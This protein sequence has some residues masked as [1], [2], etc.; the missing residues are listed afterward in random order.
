M[1]P[2]TPSRKKEQILETLISQL[3]EGPIS[4]E[5]KGHDDDDD[6]EQM[7]ETVVYLFGCFF[8][9]NI[10]K[11]SNCLLSL[12]ASNMHASLHLMTMKMN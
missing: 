3:S 11:L 8:L 12:G 9:T 7:H 10:N 6:D 5:G 2:I 1:G 4:L